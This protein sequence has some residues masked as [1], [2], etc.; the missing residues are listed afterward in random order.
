YDFDDVRSA[1]VSAR[2]GRSRGAEWDL[3]DGDDDEEDGD[4]DGHE[5]EGPDLSSKGDVQD[6]EGPSEPLDDAANL[7]EVR[8]EPDETDP[9][10][11]EAAAPPHEAR[12][13]D[14]VEPGPPGSPRRVVRERPDRPAVRRGVVTVPPAL[15]AARRCAAVPR[16]RPVRDLPDPVRGDGDEQRPRRR[17]ARDGEALDVPPA[18]AGAV[19]VV[20]VAQ[21]RLVRES[22]QGPGGG[23]RFPAPAP[24]PSGRVRAEGAKARPRGRPRLVARPP[25]RRQSHAEGVLDR[26]HP[27]RRGVLGRAQARLPGDVQTRRGW[28][29]HAQ[30]GVDGDQRD[31]AGGPPRGS[32]RERPVQDQHGDQVRLA[33]VGR[34]RDGRAGRRERDACRDAQDRRVAPPA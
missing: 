11:E 25:G 8:E 22:P 16:G 28:S 14:T 33:P 6:S 13:P 7:A 12:Q 18:P 26:G 2:N 4:G 10:E 15:P 3:R 5:Q 17:V 32:E 20:R 23:R 31:E 30:P 24:V 34:P 27:D 19:P 21:A 1:D 9:T 29:R